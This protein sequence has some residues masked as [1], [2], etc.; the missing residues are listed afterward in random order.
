M[1]TTSSGMSGA[2][3]A[4]RFVRIAAGLCCASLGSGLHA[5]IVVSDGFAPHGGR[6]VPVTIT[7]SG[8]TAATT[9]EF[10]GT[11]A[12]G[13]TVDSDT[14]ISAT[15]PAAFVTGPIGVA[16]G[17][18]NGAS[19]FHFINRPGDMAIAGPTAR[20]AL[21]LGVLYNF[22]PL[23]DNAFGQ[24]GGVTY[25]FENMILP[26]NTWVYFGSVGSVGI[27]MDN[28]TPSGGEIM[29]YSPADSNFASGLIVYRGTSQMNLAAPWGPGNQVCTRLV[30]QFQ[31]Y[32]PSP[33][34]PVVAADSVGLPASMGGVAAIPPGSKF[35]LNLR[36]EAAYVSGGCAS[37]QPALALYDAAPTYAGQLAYSNYT[38]GFYYENTAPELGTIADQV[39]NDGG[40]TPALALSVADAETT[41]DGVTLTATSSD[42]AFVPSTN[43]VIAGTGASRTVTAGTVA[44]EAGPATITVRGT[45]AAGVFSEETFVVAKNTPPTISAIADQLVQIGQPTSAIAFTVGDIETELTSL[46]LVAVS[47]NQP[48]VPDANLTLGGSGANRTIVAVPFGSQTGQA[49]ITITV[50]DGGGL[51]ESKS[52]V[53]SVNA[54]PQLTTNAAATANQGQSVTLTSGNLN[55]SDVESGA[56]EIRYTLNPDGGGT[57]GRFGVVRLSGVP[58]GDGGTFTQQ[59]IN[60]G[61]VSFLHD[62]SCNFPA[63]FNFDIDDGDGGY[64][65]APLSP[66][67]AGVNIDLRND[68]PSANPLSIAVPLGGTVNDSVSGSD[69]DCLSSDPLSYAHVVASG[70]SKGTITAFNA[71]NGAFSYAA[72]PGQSGADSFQFEISDGA[73]TVT[74]TVSIQ[75][76]NQSPMAQDG[77]LAAIERTALAGTLLATDSD[78]PAQPLT[79]AIATPPNKGTI[80]GFDSGTGAFTYTPNAN[81]IGDDSFSF[82]ASDGTLTSA[83]ATVSIAIR[84]IIDYGD[85][86]VANS[87]SG[88]TNGEVWIIDPVSGDQFRLGAG[89][90]LDGG[91]AQGVTFE[92]NGNVLVST[93]SAKI[94]RVD[95]GTGAVS[96]VSD[97]GGGMLL[98]LQVDADGSILAA[99]GSSGVR[100]IDPVSGAVLATYTGTSL[101]LATDVDL[102]PD[103]RLVVSD[104]GAFAS[105]TNKLLL[106]DPATNAETNTGAAGLVLP[107]SVAR[108]ADGRIAVGDGVPSFGASPSTVKIID[109]GDGSVDVT[110]SDVALAGVTGLGVDLTGRLY[111]TS[112]G[113]VS[114]HAH[115]LGGGAPTAVSSSGGLTEPWAIAVYG[116]RGADLQI[117]KDN[118]RVG[119]L[120]G[121]TITYAVVVTNAGPDAV[122][123]AT[124]ADTLP[125]TLINGSWACQQAQSTATCPVPASGSGHLNALV[126]LGVGQWLRFD[127]TAEVDGT[128]G[129]FVTNTA[130]LI[131]PTGVPEL[132]TGNNSS[133]DSDAIMPIGLFSDGFETVPPR[134]LGVPGANEALR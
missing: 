3:P 68:P 62:D 71:G 70:P 88:P 91:K 109:S 111:G 26:A 28:D 9:V 134:V 43:I 38:T 117:A 133:S 16:D 74:G 94:L 5:Q 103:G 97:V 44:G 55:S 101:A 2:S 112:L 58:L 60:D 80:S 77:T 30:L 47:N 98:G 102:M 19:K 6:G 79:Y 129:A 84:A 33:L 86:A 130:T 126:D 54:P 108:L 42:I 18:T 51:S 119:L 95:A 11:A 14:Q 12:A 20:N 29:T 64:G 85:L 66:Y 128:V 57:A 49:T 21:P 113:N 4:M 59:D 120:D 17:V 107:I 25:T 96:E 63:E 69:T 105:S 127:V 114:V 31:P 78:L 116:D 13:F 87:R 36:M 75:I 56:S 118:H 1:T 76:E 48:L 46:S 24:A 32:A 65:R 41:A 22:S 67:R 82:T 131:A 8:F 83:A 39:V 27:S 99:N 40:S 122:R 100:R 50:T 37:W 104:G 132:G 34:V 23:A 52:F 93:E 110:I 115:D 61:L 7:G 15:A 89:G 10:A 72:T 73:N 121:E 106:I 124:L 53:L 35:Q 92:A 45:D 123:G 125:A 90:L 81:R